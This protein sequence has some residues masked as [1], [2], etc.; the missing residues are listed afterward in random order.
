MDNPKAK[1][2]LK[3]QILTASKEHLL[4]ILFDGAIRFSEQGRIA[5]QEKRYEDS[6]NLFI[7]AQRIMIELVS[8]LNKDILPEDMYTN[9]VR[10]YNFVYF[11]L[12]DANMK[13]LPEKAEEALRI[14]RHLR[15]TWG[16]AIEQEHKR[17]FPAAELVDRAQKTR[18][19]VEMEC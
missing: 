9:I 3:N 11:R 10:L 17:K 2:Y 14:L 4:L 15:E 1:E 13:R 19:D 12:I 5:L 18:R 7:R 6:C 16:L 8:S